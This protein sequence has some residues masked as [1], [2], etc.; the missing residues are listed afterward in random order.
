[1]ESNMRI[2]PF[3]ALLVGM[4]G[5]Y[6]EEI[7]E[8]SHDPAND[9]SSL[10]VSAKERP[11]YTVTLKDGQGL[12]GYL[13][14]ENEE[15]I[16]I[17]FGDG[18]QM[19]IDKKIIKNLKR[20]T[21]VPA[22]MT[23]DMWYPDPNRTTYLYSPSAFMLGKGTVSFSQKELFFSSVGIGVSEHVDLYAG[24]AVPL[25]FMEEGLNVILGGKV[26]GE[27][28]KPLSIALGMQ[29]LIIPAEGFALNLPYGSITVGDHDKH[30]TFSISPPF[31]V[32]ADE[33]GFGELYWFSFCGILRLNKHFALVTENWLFQIEDFESPFICGLAGRILGKHLST[34]IGL[35]F[36]E[37]MEFPIPWIDVTYHW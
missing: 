32:G 26:G 20:E 33:S 23:D 6:S 7:I 15:S 14:K 4:T 12:K 21:L 31:T 19:T 8:Q 27:I 30:A 29:T 22:D 13:V 28:A 5:A 17:E 2:I 34:D 37:K 1:M 3:M 35:F 11:L 24:A 36:Y 18:N 16:V 25:W 10:E 9:T